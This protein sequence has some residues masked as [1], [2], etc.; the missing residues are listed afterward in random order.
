MIG[1]HRKFMYVATYIIAYFIICRN[2]LDKSSI[3]DSNQYRESFLEVL[4]DIQD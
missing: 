1:R 2:C 3:K 4:D